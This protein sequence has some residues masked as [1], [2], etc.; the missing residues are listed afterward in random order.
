MKQTQQLAKI[1]NCEGKT[2]ILAFYSAQKKKVI[3]TLFS[4]L[5]NAVVLPSLWARHSA[6]TMKGAN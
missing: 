3:P 5:G 4:S 6:E 2:E 1:Y